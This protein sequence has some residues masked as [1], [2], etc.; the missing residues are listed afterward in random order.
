VTLNDPDEN[1]P[2]N[3][4]QG[5]RI[6][7]L[8]LCISLF[9]TFSIATLGFCIN[10]LVQPAFAITNCYAKLFFVFSTIIG[11]LSLSSGA[12]ACLTRLS[13]F[14]ATAQVVRHRG[15]PTKAEA[16]AEWRA[17]YQRMGKR[18]WG[19][20]KCQ[21]LFFGL[22]LAFLMLTLGTTYWRRLS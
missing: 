11:L 20:F 2:Y 21:L 3:R 15:D 22:Q 12:M 6:A 16:V 14:R 4:W 8:T 19:L 10:L 7:Q 17:R 18:T 5:L 9:L 13:D 1:E